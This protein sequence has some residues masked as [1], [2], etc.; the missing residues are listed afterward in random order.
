[1]HNNVLF[2]EEKKQMA[3][4]FKC[5]KCG[6]GIKAPDKAAGKTAKCP[7]C[8]EV[9]V[10]PNLEQNMLRAG[11]SHILED[12]CDSKIVA[13]L[14]DDRF[15]HGILCSEVFLDHGFAEQDGVRIR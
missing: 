10:V 7:K 1:M 2:R 3:I 15:T 5:N 13:S 12:S 9:L 4:R 11:N 14:E 8:K 6:A